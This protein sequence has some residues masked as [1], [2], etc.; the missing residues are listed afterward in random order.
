MRLGSCVAVA[1]VQAGGCSSHS[2]PSLGTSI[3]IDVALKT[4]NN[5]K[6][7]VRRIV[8]NVYPSHPLSR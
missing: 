4:K 3:C 1:V 7:H 2:T 6:M 8:V 5:L